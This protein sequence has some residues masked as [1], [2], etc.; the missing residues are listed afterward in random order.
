VDARVDARISVFLG[1]LRE[2]RERACDL[3]EGWPAGHAEG[4]LIGPEKPSEHGRGRSTGHAV[5]GRVV[6][7][8]RRIHEGLP[9]R[10]Q[11]GGVVLISVACANGGD[12]PPEV[13]EVACI[14]PGYVAIRDAGVDQRQKPCH[15]PMVEPTLGTNHAGDATPS[16]G[17][18]LVPVL[19]DLC[20]GSRALRAALAA[21]ALHLVVV[22][23]VLLALQWRWPG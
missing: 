16:L 8:G 17:R 6:G 1:G 14:R 5:G 22:A 10:V 15:V 7:K 23:G 21:N 19:G 4:H 2:A 3:R 18:T 13:V 20:L 12:G 9:R 11:S